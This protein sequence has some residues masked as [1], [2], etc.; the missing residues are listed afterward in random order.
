MD[1]MIGMIVRCLLQMAKISVR[2]RG[3]EMLSVIQPRAPVST[4]IFLWIKSDD[5]RINECFSLHYVS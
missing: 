2:L 1:T 4:L 5:G 3:S